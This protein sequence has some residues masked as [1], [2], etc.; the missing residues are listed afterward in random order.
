MSLAGAWTDVLG[1]RLGVIFEVAARFGR[2]AGQ[3]V[4][5]ARR[6]AVLASLALGLC[7]A[8][9]MAVLTPPLQAPDEAQHFE[10]AYQL[11]ELRIWSVVHG[12]Q[13]GDVLPVSL[14]DMTRRFLGST[15]LHQARIVS[16]EPIGVT[17]RE[18]SRPLDPSRRTFVDFTGAAFYSPLPYLPQAAAIAA[19]RWVGFGPMVLLYLAR[20]ANAAASVGLLALAIRLLP[21]G[22]SVLMLIGLLP[23]ALF[24]YGSASP[25]AMTL[26][27]AFLFTALA[28]RAQTVG[29]WSRRA[30]ALGACAGLIFCSVKPVYTPLLLTGLV[31]A[32]LEQGRRWTALRDQALLLLVVCVPTV[33]WTWS[34]PMIVA[35]MLPNVQPAGQISF[36][37]HHPVNFAVVLARTLYEDKSFYWHSLVGTLGWLNV[38]LPRWAYKAPVVGLVAAALLD[39]GLRRRLAP[40]AALWQLLLVAGGVVLTLTA[41]YLGW[42]PVGGPLI[43]GVQGRYF[44][45]LAAMAGLSA[46]AL[47]PQLAPP[48]MQSLSVLVVGAIATAELL[49]ALSAIVSDYQVF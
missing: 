32:I 45:S 34:S 44:L 12:D 27:S 47:V 19:G 25:D 17:A 26:A 5:G 10:R 43:L 36:I 48:R 23:M 33:L 20:L 14:P 6:Q 31:P 35:A 41:L 11:S 13:A 3:L 1:R 2:R 7:G 28:V 22:R 9:S 49:A 16:P 40:A 18:L 8:V 30:L 42:T 46:S 4:G 15:T 29:G 21:A 38:D 39:G 37:L 24:L